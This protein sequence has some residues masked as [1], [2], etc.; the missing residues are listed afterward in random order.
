MLKNY[1]LKLFASIIVFG[2]SFGNATALNPNKPLTIVASSST[3]WVEVQSENGI[4]ISFLKT[5]ENGKSY[6]NIKF[7]N[8]SSTSIKFDWSLNRGSD[9]IGDKSINTEIKSTGF[10]IKQVVINEGSLEDFSVTI[11]FK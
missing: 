4:R 5:Q 7:E 3:D 9:I 8:G 2:V 1:K 6:L 11:N 10:E